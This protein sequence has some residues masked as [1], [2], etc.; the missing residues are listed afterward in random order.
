MVI[1]LFLYVF[2]MFS[3]CAHQSTYLKLKDCITFQLGE[4]F[5]IDLN[6]LIDQSQSSPIFSSYLL[7]LDLNVDMQTTGEYKG[8]I[9]SP[10]NSY[11][12]IC[13]VIDTK[14]PVLTL[15]KNIFTF[16]ENEIIDENRILDFLTIVDANKIQS[17][18]ILPVLSQLSCGEHTISIQ[19]VDMANNTSDISCKV[20][21]TKNI[22]SSPSS[23]S[24]PQDS[25]IKNV[26]PNG[27]SKINPNK[28][29]DQPAYDEYP[30]QIGSLAQLQEYAKTLNKSHF[31]TN[32]TL[33]DGSEM[34]GLWIT[35]E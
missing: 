30:H 2:V 31:I 21:I 18:I 28:Q 27:N 17:V 10:W 7:K 22:F 20:I 19:V 23:S 15:Q 16:E 32:I 14:P 1:K 3:I 9:H 13:K 24:I 11:P 33:N 12:I 25:V 34:Y 5:H 35:D 29:C 4:T 26:C 8:W 6:S